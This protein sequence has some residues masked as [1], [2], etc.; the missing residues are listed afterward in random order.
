M[1]RIATPRR[2]QVSS[3][4]TIIDA[5]LPNRTIATKCLLNCQSSGALP[6]MLQLA[7]DARRI[8]AADG[9]F[10]T[11]FRSEDL[12]APD[13]APIVAGRAM[14]DVTFRRL[15]PMW[16]RQL[17]MDRRAGGGGVGAGMGMGARR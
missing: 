2:A 6:I 13:I 10:V 14:N 17:G 16:C 11:R 4:S 15:P 3:T 12:A 5:V 8:F 1:A 9:N 7:L